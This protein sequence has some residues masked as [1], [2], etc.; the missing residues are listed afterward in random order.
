[1]FCFYLQ[2]DTDDREY[3]LVDRWQKRK[4]IPNRNNEY[5]QKGWGDNIQANAAHLS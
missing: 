3:P 4:I 5:L 1:M 2:V